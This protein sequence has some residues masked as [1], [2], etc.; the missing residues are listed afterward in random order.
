MVHWP[1]IFKLLSKLISISKVDYRARDEF[2]MVA[3][4]TVVLL[5][6]VLSQNAHIFEK[7]NCG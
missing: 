1:R 5:V 2:T 7:K 4:E 3:G 6:K